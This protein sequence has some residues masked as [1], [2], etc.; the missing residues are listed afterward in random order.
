MRIKDLSKRLVLCICVLVI[1]I[2][3]SCKETAEDY[4][5]DASCFSENSEENSIEDS[6]AIPSQILPRS[7]KYKRVVVSKYDE[8]HT[9]LSNEYVALEFQHDGA[10]EDAYWI[11]WGRSDHVLSLGSDYMQIKDDRLI[12]RCWGDS[13]YC[14]RILSE[15]EIEYL[16]DESRPIPKEVGGPRNFPAGTR[17]RLSDEE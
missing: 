13:I 17:F 11:Y 7:G 4:M 10:D 9:W 1:P 12:L 3:S 6:A 5:Y 8:N 2:L 15:T 16:P 14:F